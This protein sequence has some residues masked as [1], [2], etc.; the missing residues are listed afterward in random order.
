MV[1]DHK[2]TQ[3]HAQQ[4]SEQGRFHTPMDRLCLVQT[5]GQVATVD[6]RLRTSFC[7]KPMDD[8]GLLQR[9]LD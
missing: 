6:H 5:P 8:A 2:A 1:V 9:M 7:V 4:R 3:D